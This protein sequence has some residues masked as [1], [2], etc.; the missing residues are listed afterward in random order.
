MKWALLITLAVAASGLAFW[1]LH[2]T[3]RAVDVKSA[4]SQRATSS[5]G[6]EVQGMG[7]VEPVSEVRKLMLRAGGI[8]KRCS[9]KAGDTMRVGEPILELEDSTQRAEVEVARK[10]LELARAE[11]DH[12][13]AGVNPYRIQVAEQT[14]ERL[15]EKSRYWRSEGERLRKLIATHAASEQEYQAVETQ[16]RQTEVELREQ[17][18]ELEHLRKHVTAEHRALLEAKVRSAR[19]SL[20]L[21]EE[22]LR[23]T[24]LTAPFNGTVLKLLK[25]E[26]EG[27]RAFEPEPVVLFG[28]LSRLRVRA[29][30]DERFVQR[31]AAGQTA[32]VYGR[33]L[34]GQTHPGR[35]ALLEQVMG[36]KTVFARSAAERKDLDVLEVLID[37]EP[38]F[39]APV[40]LQVDVKIR[41]ST[42]D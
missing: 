38:D 3:S 35:V 20:E 7:H 14:A 33:N 39:R 27:V 26:G 32:M 15:R 18:A 36:D 1:Q 5:E 4:P 42:R 21:A 10:N 24:K 28:D 40:G 37:M 6:P 34:T 29:E 31:L 17:E 13:N 23:E 19:S 25:R 41:L 22:R 2:V 16:R 12:V 8:V 9:V 11:A 30:I